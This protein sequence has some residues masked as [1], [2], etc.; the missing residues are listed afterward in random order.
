MPPDTVPARDER[1][2]DQPLTHPQQD[3]LGI[4][5]HAAVLAG[6]VSTTPT[7]FTIGVYGEWG[8][9]KTTF[10]RFVE[11]YLALEKPP[12]A[13]RT[14]FVHFEGWQHRT[15][16]ELWRALMLNMARAVY[17]HT[18]GKDAVAPHAAA[19]EDGKTRLRRLLGSYAA[20]GDPPPEKP[21]DQYWTFVERLD[22][23]LYGGISKRSPEAL[24]L[25][26]DVAVLAAVRASMA[27]LSAASPV[28]AG[29]R[30]LLRIDTT[31]DAA[32][33]FQRERN[34]ATRERIESRHE[35]Q[36]ALTSLLKMIPDGE[37][38]CVFLDD[39]DRCMPD[40]VL[41]LLEAIKIFLHVEKMVFVVAADEELI[42]KGLR[43]RYRELVEGS[44]GAQEGEFLARK[45]QEYFEK[46]IQ[47]RINLPECTPEHAHRFIAA[48]YPEWMPATDII[49]SAVG[50]NPRRL[51]QYCSWLVFRRR[52]DH[53]ER[54]K[55]REEKEKEREPQQR[56]RQKRSTSRETYLPAVTDE[57]RA[58]RAMLFDKL[59]A[60]ASRD[61]ESVTLLHGLARE[62]DFATLA[63]QLEEQLAEPAPTA[64]PQTGDGAAQAGTGS[65]ASAGSPHAAA[66]VS[67]SDD[68]ASTVPSNSTGQGGAGDRA[69]AKAAD[70]TA[71]RPIGNGAA[72]ATTTASEAPFGTGE[73][74][75]QDAAADE[76]PNGQLAR[77][78]RRIKGSVSLLKHFRAE[79]AL[80]AYA[81]RDVETLAAMADVHPH[82]VLMLTS[83]DGPFM[84][85]LRHLAQP[86][87]SAPERLVQ[88][89]L[90]RL[91]A[92]RTSYPPLFSLLLALAAENAATPWSAGA[93]ALESALQTRDPQGLT[94]E[95][96]TLFEDIRDLDQAAPADMGP[97]ALL[98]QGPRLSE[99]LPEEVRA[100]GAFENLPKPYQPFSQ[101]PLYRAATQT[102]DEKRRG[103]ARAVFD[104]LEPAI[105]T[106]VLVRLELRQWAAAYCLEL[107]G[108]ARL[109]GLERQW[110]ELARLLRT[111]R[112]TLRALEGEAMRP[113][114]IAP[115]HRTVWDRYS[116]DER[117]RR[118]LVLKPLVSD[119]APAEV[120]EYFSMSQSIAPAP[121]VSVAPPPAMAAP[122]APAPRPRFDYV[123]VVVTLVAKD[124]LPEPGAKRRR[125]VTFAVT[126][127]GPGGPVEAMTAVPW[128]QL[129]E[130]MPTL[131]SEELDGPPAQAL[132]AR[133]TSQRP[134]SSE[135]VLRARGALMWR[136]VFKDEVGKRMQEL[137]ATGAA[138][139]L[140]LDFPSPLAPLPWETLYLEQERSFL[141]LTQRYSLV[142]HMAS[143]AFPTSAAIM[144]PLRILAVLV[145]LPGRPELDLEAE[146]AAIEEAVR[147]GLQDGRVLLRVL[148]NE[149]ADP[150][151]LQRALRTFL[152][153]VFH[154]A[155]HGAFSEGEGGLLLHSPDGRQVT[156]ASQVATLLRDAG[157]SLAFLNS[158]NTG[159]AVEN[160]AITSVAGSLVTAGVPAVI[161][162]LD[163][164]AD[165][166][167]MLFTREWYRA[168][169]EGY[170]LEP[171]LA[172]ARKR[173]SVD[174]WD[175]SAFTLFSSTRDLDELMFPQGTFRKP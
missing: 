101:S 21:Q 1:T 42:G 142:R 69:P 129:L 85:A 131:Y 103:M 136:W 59:I 132:G 63:K 135:S 33:L 125:P 73:G 107:R 139:R 5:S 110:P 148:E 149:E 173:L 15:A 155:G 79:P 7:P 57:E 20:G 48:Q 43:L 174:R 97:T 68:T 46:I 27:A 14:L 144:T 49:L 157:I 98:L 36:D 83:G 141:G 167:G 165:E 91:V 19:K 61:A 65:G 51:K 124:S 66:P 55:K 30:Q 171:A 12:P 39:L 126:L 123:D 44:A 170:P 50:S 168:F 147:P 8:A 113:G 146:L 109:N 56:R 108:F 115:E 76:T 105:L 2:S 127:D 95:W 37:R 134:R 41:D 78:C 6:V 137:H 156:T 10:V 45:G 166:A 90:A 116:G 154:F 47:L 52:V 74:A 145:N 92:M 35:F 81:R 87:T 88:E 29:L 169:A 128:A 130:V 117:L 138:Y 152:P 23:T 164:I 11:H 119:I 104:A 112:A 62:K 163:L 17:E 162:G 13:E 4:A 18:G 94:A 32:T 24:R 28:V 9:G 53:A 140:L 31:V 70:G 96:A 67:V 102:E 172:E 38:V 40:V 34:E 3:L 111:D 121:D 158:C 72:S 106:D 77:L 22:S 150:S 64:R 89:D 175:W 160:D 54:E 25:D 133:E 151:G 153:H 86:G 82:P 80:S 100:L 16:D 71:L 122:Q 99:I 120:R 159:T 84:R 58:A 60:L 75:V 93:R 118:F 114:S 26:Q 161:A 143:P